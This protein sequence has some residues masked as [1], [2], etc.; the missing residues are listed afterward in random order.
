MASARISARPGPQRSTILPV[1]ERPLSPHK[2]APIL[3]LQSMQY[4][5]FRFR[6]RPTLPNSDASRERRSQSS[7]GRE[8][9][10][11]TAASSIVGTY[12]NPSSL[13]AI[14]VRIDHSIGSRMSIFGRYNHAPSSAQVRADFASTNTVA[15]KPEKAQTLTVGATAIISARLSNELRVNFSRAEAASR[16]HLD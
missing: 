3:S 13:N 4:R 16:Y 8:P 6:R 7:R 2:G 14:S 10:P 15:D 11:S 1:V 12:S 5:N 9:T